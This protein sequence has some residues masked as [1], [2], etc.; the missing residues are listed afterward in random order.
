MTPG[1][2]ILEDEDLRE[3][4]STR[5]DSAGNVTLSVG[6]QAID[7]AAEVTARLG[8]HNK[9][10]VLLQ[11][12]A[13]MYPPALRTA[14]S[15]P[16]D[17]ERTTF[18]RDHVE[19]QEAVR[20]AALSVRGRKAFLDEEDE[21]EGISVQGEGDQRIFGLLY[22]TGS[23]RSARGV[24]N[25]SAVP[26]VERA[27]QQSVRQGAGEQGNAEAGAAPEGADPQA[28]ERLRELEEQLAR[29]AAERDELADQVTDSPEPFDGYEELNA[30]DTIK[31]LRDGGYKEFGQRGLEAVIAF[32][33]AQSK[34]RKTVIEAAQEQI[35]AIPSD[36][37]D[38]DE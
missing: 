12:H 29:V 28:E 30:E 1:D 19:L 10:H 38:P 15:R 16:V 3:F 11:R 14:L 31:R 8:V 32:E 13:K 18:L 34:P 2:A 25:Y 5:R 21:I 24:I 17:G 37:A 36:D 9:S 26:S 23:G 4:R 22:R 6:P 35:D 20:T 27:F 33:E 7:S